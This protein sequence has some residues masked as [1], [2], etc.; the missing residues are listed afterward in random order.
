MKKVVIISS[1][2]Y[3][4]NTPRA[5]RATELAKE[6]GRQGYEVVVYA[7]LGD[8]DYSDF[9]TINNVKIVNLGRNRFSDFNSSEKIEI[10]KVSKVRQIWRKVLT[11]TLEYPDV[12]LI[13]LVFKV[14]R[15]EKSIDLLISVA[16]PYP[17]HWGI[18]L[19][20]AIY[21]KKLANV[22]WVADCGDP[23]MGNAISRKLF[24]FGY[25]EKLFCKQANY[26][27][28]PASSAIEGYYK[29]YHPKIVI[30]PQGF[31]FEEIDY[32]LN[33]I[34]NKPIKFIYAG[35]FYNRVRD[36][37]PLLD[38][39]CTVDF[40]FE[41][42][43]YTRL[44]NILDEYTGKLGKKLVVY[45][46]IERALLLEE[47]SKADFLINFENNSEVQVPSKLIDYALV[48]RPILS[49]NSSCKLDTSLVDRFLSGEYEDGLVIDDVEQ[50]NIVNVVNRFGNLI[51]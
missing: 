17:I 37:R 33:Y 11:K 42:V 18:G 41:F 16:L 12:G 21:P 45:D 5:N 27:A 35:A 29:D 30:I 2:F 31:K 46:Y 34:A 6:F 44:T 51:N 24:Y 13:E 4:R 14:L 20:R 43:I 32:S 19:F 7:L 50:Y 26:I 49:I 25:L 47:M 40:D 15:K 10:K 3:P 36:P 23:Y 39:L 8:F 9:E 22:V 38:Y 1:V 28:I 48:K